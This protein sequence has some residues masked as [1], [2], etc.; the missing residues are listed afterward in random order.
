MVMP[1]SSLP[2]TSAPSLHL[3]HWDFLSV[4]TTQGRSRRSTSLHL[5]YLHAS[6]N[7]HSISPWHLPFWP[8][9]VLSLLATKEDSFNHMTPP[10]T[11]FL[12]PQV[13]RFQCDLPADHPPFSTLQPYPPAFCSLPMPNSLPL[14]DLLS[15]DHS[16]PRGPYGFKVS[17]QMSPPWRSQLADICLPTLLSWCLHSIYHWLEWFCS[18]LVSLFTAGPSSLPPHPCHQMWV[19]PEEGPC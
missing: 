11:C 19:L 12:W 15:L 1:E 13:M 3:I 2:C 9:T 14:Q 6:L 10:L 17:V 16:V 5:P 18:C 4:L 7:C 8:P